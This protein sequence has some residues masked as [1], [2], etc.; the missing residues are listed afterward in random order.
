MKN[1]EEVKLIGLS[2]E[3]KSKEYWREKK[4]QGCLHCEA[5]GLCCHLV[6]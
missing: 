2:K 1:I 3:F 5:G 4:G 6:R